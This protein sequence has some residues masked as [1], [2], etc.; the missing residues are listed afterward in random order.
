MRG[1]E[2]ALQPFESAVLHNSSTTKSWTLWVP[3]RTTEEEDQSQMVP[4]T[5]A[6]TATHSR[7]RARCRRSDVSLLRPLRIG[8][9][10][11]GFGCAA[12][13]G[14]GSLAELHPPPQP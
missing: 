14:V 4:V 8:I 3:K 5:S 13:E 1:A 9:R 10:W 11:L 6:A 2:D 12:C 7:A